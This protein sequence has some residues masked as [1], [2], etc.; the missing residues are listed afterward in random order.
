MN[1][2]AI[3]QMDPS[4]L[5]FTFFFNCCILQNLNILSHMVKR[6][7]CIT[8][9]ESP[10]VLYKNKWFKYISF[11]D[12]IVVVKTMKSGSWELIHLG[13]VYL[14]LS[15][16]LW[17]WQ[18]SPPR[19][20]CLALQLNEACVSFPSWHSQSEELKSFDILDFELNQPANS[21]DRYLC[22]TGL[23]RLYF[24]NIQAN[25]QYVFSCFKETFYF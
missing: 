2:S 23:R 12:I 8:V 5:Y 9:V 15:K 3:M 17:T 20:H 22:S 16:S 11:C 25:V 13:P 14:P 24:P 4:F 19:G 18:E 6:F 10:A 21:S 1:A 7:S